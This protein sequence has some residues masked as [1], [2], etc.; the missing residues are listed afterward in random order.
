MPNQGGWGR[1]LLGAAV[2]LPTLSVSGQDGTPGVGPLAP[3]S[4]AHAQDGSCPPPTWNPVYDMNLSTVVQGCNYSGLVNGAGRYGLVS[5]DWQNGA[6]VWGA[7]PT[8]EW[9]CSAV[10]L[11]QAARV[12]AEDNRTRVFV[13]RNFCLALA[14]LRT[15]REAMGDPA[16]RHFFLQYQ[17]G[18][19]AGITPGTIFDSPMSQNQ[20]QYFWNWTQPEVLQWWR[21][22]ILGPDAA[23]SPFID[24]IFTDDVDGTFQEHG[25]AIAAM[26]MSDDQVQAV[27][28]ATQS[29]YTTLLR[30]LIEARAYNWQAFGA[31]DWT[32]ALL[33]TKGGAACVA[34]MRALCTAELRAQPKLISAPGA[35]RA[36]AV[37]PLGNMRQMVA[38]FLVMRG[39]YWWFGQGWSG[40]TCTSHRQPLPFPYDPLWDISPGHPLT[41]CSEPTPGVFRRAFEHGVAAL[42]CNNFNATLDF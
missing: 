41:N 22:E 25:D 5:F 32:Q 12:K 24:G 3:L 26:G 11:A 28:D 35:N 37:V 15:Q 1:R 2:V 30:A 18:N 33:P 20:S 4:C 16:K 7:A 6:D 19:P 34:S 38:A 13:Y 40:H 23:G 27:S 36:G 42:D 17:P 31:E 14:V 9:N 10:A 29:A 21:E 8:G 39:P